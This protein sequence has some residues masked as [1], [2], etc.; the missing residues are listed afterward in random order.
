MFLIWEGNRTIIRVDHPPQNLFH[1]GPVALA[2]HQIF[3]ADG[4]L[5][6][7]GKDG[8]NIFEGSDHDAE[9][10]HV[11]SLP[12]PCTAVIT[13]YMYRSM[14]VRL[15]GVWCGPGPVSGIVGIVPYASTGRELCTD[16]FAP[17][18]SVSEN[19]QK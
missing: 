9:K 19:A 18:V 2:C 6:F 14:W 8:K 13:L 4:V 1:T 12:P 17:Y 11:V 5:G 7:P 10:P 15:S 16:A 3:D